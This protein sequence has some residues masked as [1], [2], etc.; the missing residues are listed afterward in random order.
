M[1]FD[2]V[3]GGGQQVAVPPAEVS[4]GRQQGTVPPFDPVTGG[5][6]QG[7]VPPAEVSGVGQQGTVPPAE[8]RR[9]QGTVLDTLAISPE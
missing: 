6:Q 2:P 5:G 3:T 8:V 7:T 1:P 9:Q 4:G